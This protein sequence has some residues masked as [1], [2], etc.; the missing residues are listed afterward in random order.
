VFGGKGGKTFGKRGVFRARGKRG[1]GILYKEE[2]E[3]Q[4]G[5]RMLLEDGKI[6]TRKKGGGS[7][8]GEGEREKN[9][10]K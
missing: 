2:G 1:G 9:N 10:E 8:R 3:H 7:E 4:K 5:T 6:A